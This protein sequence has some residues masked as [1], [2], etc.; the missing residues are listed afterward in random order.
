MPCGRPRSQGVKPAGMDL[1]QDSDEALAARAAAG[2]GG[3]FRTLYDR[4]APRVRAMAARMLGDDHQ[5]LD[6]VQDVFARAWAALGA[7]D[8]GRPWR[9]WLLA[10]A[11]RAVVD[12]LRRRSR[13]KPMPDDDRLPDS[14]PRPEAVVACREELDR[15]RG[16]LRRVPPP[17]RLVLLLV[18]QERLSYEEVAEALGVTVNLVR[19]RLFR[20]LRRLG[21]RWDR[22]TLKGVRPDF[23]THLPV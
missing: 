12:E 11:S 21:T 17:L 6:L 19:V 9:P 15:V 13:W 5:T 3:A 23:M 8:P 20:G 16:A 2:D 18:F 4:H 14:A 22:G 10:I 1:A 7:Y